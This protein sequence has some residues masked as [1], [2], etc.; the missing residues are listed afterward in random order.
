MTTHTTTKE[1][2]KTGFFVRKPIVVLS[3]DNGWTCYTH[4]PQMRLLRIF[5]RKDFKRVNDFRAGK[6]ECDGIYFD[7]YINPFHRKQQIEYT[8]HVFDDPDCIIESIEVTAI[9]GEYNE[10]GGCCDRETSIVTFR[11]GKEI[12]LR[13]D[14][15][16]FYTR[17]KQFSYNHLVSQIETNKAIQQLLLKSKVPDLK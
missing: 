8:F 2:T 1:Y 17:S 3:H 13:T 15:D 12:I 9:I 14:T 4:S 6:M 11:D 7:Y 5:N 10:C 16:H